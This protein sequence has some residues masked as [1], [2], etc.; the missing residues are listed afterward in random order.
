MGCVDSIIKSHNQGIIYPRVRGQDSC[1]CRSRASCPLDG[2]CQA[3]GII[4]NAEVTTDKGD[5][6]NYIGLTDNSFKVRYTNHKSSFTH[7]GQI[8]S[9]QLSKHIWKIKDN[10][11]PY[12]INWSI[13]S[14]APSYSN[15]SNRCQLCL[16]EK[17]HIITANKSKLLNRRSEL[18]S[19]CRHQ[20]NFILGNFPD[21]PVKWNRP[22]SSIRQCRYLSNNKTLTESLK[23]KIS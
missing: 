14:R 12:N 23:D 13:L 19:G 20:R 4:Y 16:T 18:V 9:T 11:M 15:T 2:K 6:K 5:V 3:K 1:N 10:N 21:P 7:R 22:V 17:L 8:N